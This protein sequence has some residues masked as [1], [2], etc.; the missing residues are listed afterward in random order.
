MGSTFLGYSFAILPLIAAHYDPRLALAGVLLVWPVVFD[1]SFTVIRRLR[2][3]QNIFTGHREFL[4]HRLVAAGWTHRAATLLYA[5]LPLIGAAFAFTWQYGNPFLHVCV[6]AALIAAC[7]SLWRFVCS[8]ERNSEM[9]APA[10]APSHLLD[11]SR[12]AAEV[13]PV[14]LT[15]VG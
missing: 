15:W 11:P 13:A 6:A 7:A 10:P 4:F 1:S 2:R 9:R 8:V 14:P 5:P 12:E 3:G